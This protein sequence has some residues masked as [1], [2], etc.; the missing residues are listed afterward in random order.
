MIT[1]H[2]IHKYYGRQ[3]VLKGVSLHV[4]PGERLGLVGPNG[5]GKSTILG[6]M[7]GTVE[8]D[9]GEVF[10]AK[11]LRL[12]YLPQELLH[13]TGQT[14][15]ELAMDT[16]EGLADL[17]AELWEVH[18]ELAADPDPARSG[19]GPAG[20]R[21]PTVTAALAA[22]ALAGAGLVDVEIS[23]DYLLEK[24]FTA[25]GQAQC[26]ASLGSRASPPILFRFCLNIISNV[27]TATKYF[28]IPF[29]HARR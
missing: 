22:L 3:D 18:Q 5:A 12:G 9:K 14:V 6:L 20:D 24:G 10:R 8:P 25:A 13:L 26:L 1:L 19:R 16:G 11:H 2:Q 27:G 4:S 15:L 21:Q 7:L 17:E 28:W 23:H 29:C